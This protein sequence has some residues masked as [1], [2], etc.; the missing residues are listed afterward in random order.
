MIGDCFA[1][2]VCLCCGDLGWDVCSGY[3]ASGIGCL[4]GTESSRGASGK[5]STGEGVE[6]IARL[7]VSA[8]AARATAAAVSGVLELEWMYSSRSS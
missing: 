2:Q 5:P 8:Q 6:R 3:R 1:L 7:K 4:P